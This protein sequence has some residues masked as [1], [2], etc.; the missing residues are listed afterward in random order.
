MKTS[1][2]TYIGLFVVLLFFSSGSLVDGDYKGKSKGKGRKNKR[3]VSCSECHS[4][5]IQ[6]KY[7][8]EPAVDAC[9]NCHTSNG[10]Q[11]PKSENN[12]FTLADPSPTL[13]FYCHEENSKANIHS[14][15]QEGECVMCHSP[16]SSPNSSLL[17]EKLPVLCFNCHESFDKKQSHSPV[18]EGECMACHSAHESDNASLL[19]EKE[20]SDLCL[21]CH[22]LEIGEN[23]KVH[24]AMQMGSCT[25]CHNPHHSDNSGLLVESKPQ[26]CLNCHDNIQQQIESKYPHA[27]A[28]D[29]C[30]NCH[31][32]HSSEKSS[33]LNDNIPGLCYTCH[34]TFD[35]KNGH[36]PAVEG[37]C[38][39]CHNVHGS[40]NPKLLTEKESRNLCLMCH[41]LGM[42]NSRVQHAPVIGGE[43]T[44]CHNPHHSDQNSLLQ[45]EKPQLCFN[46]HIDLSSSS[47]MSHRHE[48]FLDDCFNCHLPHHSQEDHL[49][50]DQ[51]KSL[52]LTCH[53]NINEE[54][55][56]KKI[57]H[58]AMKDEV[59]CIKCHN[60]HASNEQ[61]MLKD[62][63]KT[64][65]LS[66]HDKEIP[67]PY[68]SVRDI[69]TQIE[70]DKHVHEPVKEG[71]IDC[72]KPH[73]EDNPFLLN[74]FYA[75]LKYVPSNANNFEMCFSCHDKQLMTLKRV[76]V[77]TRFR[78]GDRNLHYVHLQGNK[79][80]N[81]NFCHDVHSS[82][83]EHLI[84]SKSQFGQWSMPIEYKAN[85][86]GG[87][88]LSGCHEKKEY[89]IIP[90]VDK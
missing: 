9:D 45:T 36:P 87:S 33:L 58:G 55:N 16:H 31:A 61:G 68:G 63:N 4:G 88:C 26:L 1:I 38:L 34:E 48:P 24:E 3:E 51:S 65:C 74:E 64:V 40:E 56:S 2:V 42:E 44:D 52:C 13:C 77:I 73:A 80:R 53:D 82:N 67:T 78:E 76:V 59:S 49:L 28:V 90:N 60:P 43:C 79:A 30:S 75:P 50:V 70:N 86:N 46:C 85:L 5:L 41:D 37:E 8:H 29:D 18:K 15:V 47:R 10:N 27:A 72:H 21:T 89:S 17:T 83:Q 54:I 22:D 71:C 39:S 69:K 14:P 6:E 20:A 35:K 7:K 32:A 57:V 12:E 62:E 84:K 19:L 11:H 25:D 23:H 66:C 81:C